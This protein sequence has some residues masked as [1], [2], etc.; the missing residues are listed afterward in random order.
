MTKRFVLFG[1]IGVVGGLSVLLGVISLFFSGFHAINIPANMAGSMLLL[2]LG[3]LLVG[4]L[5]TISFGSE[6]GE[7]KDFKFP[8]QPK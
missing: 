1:S 2:G 4:L 8:E 3:G 5:G 6:E 7:L